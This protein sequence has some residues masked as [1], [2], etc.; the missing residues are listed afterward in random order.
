MGTWYYTT[1]GWMNERGRDALNAKIS[2]KRLVRT[3]F[4]KASQPLSSGLRLLPGADPVAS[5]HHPQAARDDAQ[6]GDR[7]GRAVGDQR[8]KPQH[9]DLGQFAMGAGDRRCAAR[10]VRLDDRHLPDDAPLAHRLENGTAAQYA[11]RPLLHDIHR[12]RIVA[13]AKQDLAR[14]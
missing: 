9:V 1:N 12:T 10:H 5:V 8:Q 2:S 7:K 13:L 4:R 3:V 11:Q 6:Y 14:L